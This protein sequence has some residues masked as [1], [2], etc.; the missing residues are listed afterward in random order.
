MKCFLVI[1]F[2]GLSYL[3]ISQTVIWS[4]DFDGNGGAG[5]NWGALNQDIGGQGNYANLWYTSCVE[6]G[7]GAGN[8]G[9]DCNSGCGSNN[10]TL[11]LG[12]TSAG[13]LGAAYDA[14]GLCGWGLCTNTNRRSQSIN[15]N[16]IGQSNLTLNFNYLENGDNSNDNGV[17]EYSINGGTTWTLLSDPAKTT[18]C[19]SGQGQ[20]TAYSIALP[21]VCENISNLRIAFRWQNNDDGVGSDP[22]FAVDD[23]TITKPI[24]LPIDLIDFKAFDIGNVIQITWTTLSEANNDYFTLQSSI[25]GREWSNIS[26]IDGQGYSSVENKYS[27]N[28]YHYYQPTT[29]YRLKQTDFNGDYAFSKIISIEKKLASTFLVYPNPTTDLVS[30]STIHSKLA[31]VELYNQVGELI[32]SNSI[33]SYKYQLNL[34]ALSSGIYILKL[35]DSKGEIDFQRVVKN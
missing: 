33:N 19:G 23:I 4:E 10:I 13:D 11:H 32:L 3:G 8:C 14:G 35:T 18:I 9:C 15:I 7:Q 26:V 31:K 22:S 21:A 12:S 34:T 17:V 29:Y 6:N 20:W 25:D 28:D 5:S 27:F 30:I 16:T 1:I 2:I 24:V